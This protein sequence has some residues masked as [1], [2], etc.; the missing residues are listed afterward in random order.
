MTI[1]NIF[2]TVK[3]IYTETNIPLPPECKYLIA[4]I[5]FGLMAALNITEEQTG[6]CLELIAD[7]KD[8][9]EFQESIYFAKPVPV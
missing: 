5:E 3:N 6:R 2:D 9:D 4:G 1:D 7:C 8:F